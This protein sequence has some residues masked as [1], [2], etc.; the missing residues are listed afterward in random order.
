MQY[1][2]HFYQSADGLSLFARD[3]E[4]ETANHSIL[5]LHGLTRNS[6]DFADL[7]DSLAGDFRLVAADQRGRGMSQ[8]DENPANYQIPTYVRDMFRLLDDLD[9]ERVILI[10]TSMGGLMSMMMGNMA[11]GRISAI[12]L[13][14]I[15]PVINQSGLARI[16]GYVGKTARPRNWDEAAEVCKTLNQVA[17]PDYRDKDWQRMA[18]RTFRENPEGVPV[19]TYDPAIAAPLDADAASA[20]PDDLWPI[21]DGLREIPLL[22]V[23]GALSDIL[24][25]DTAQEMRRRHPNLDY[26]EVPNIGHA[27]MLSEPEC[28]AKIPGWLQSVATAPTG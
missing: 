18:R 6:A 17:F 21:F 12:V 8:Y 25:A 22:L 15:G 16:M 4:N 11:P 20:V 1:R 19:P 2:K 24:A 27:P 7:A 10:G 3:Y 9:I 13:N 23:R 14:D 26:L 5:C 28:N